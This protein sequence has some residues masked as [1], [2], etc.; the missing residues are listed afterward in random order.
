V[1]RSEQLTPQEQA[2]RRAKYLSGLTWHIGAFVILNAFFWALDIMGGGG[3][4]WALWITGFWGLALAFHVL[5]YIVDGRQLEARKA[6][7]YL[8]DSTNRKA[9]AG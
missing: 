7:Q 5:A 6:E 1:A 9:R 2:Q 8:A 3:L 4:G